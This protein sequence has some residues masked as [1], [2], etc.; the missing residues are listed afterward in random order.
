MNTQTWYFEDF[1]SDLSEFLVKHEDE[2]ITIS[3]D[4]LSH[5]VDEDKLAVVL[6]KFWRQGI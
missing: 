6:A 4:S 1:C 2:F 3:F 5:F